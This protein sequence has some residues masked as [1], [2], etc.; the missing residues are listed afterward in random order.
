MRKSVLFAF[1]VS[2]AAVFSQPVRAENLT[3]ADV[4]QIVGRAVAEASAQGAGNGVIA[5]VDRV[6]NVLGVYVINPADPPMMTVT[7]GRGIPAGNGLEGLQIP[8]A[9]GAIAKAIT[10]AYLSSAGHAFSTRTASQIVQENFNPGELY[11]PGGPLFGVQFSQLPCSDI[12]QGGEALGP[13][14]RRSPLGLSADPGGLPLYRNGQVVGGVGVLFDGVYGLDLKISDYDRNL[15]ELIA[16]A[17]SQGYTP[18]TD[19]V[20]R[21]T[22]DGK[23]LRYADVDARF[24][25]SAGP[26]SLNP[27]NYVA[28]AGYTPA[29][30][31]EGT[32]FAS[33]ISG[34]R[35]DAGVS[36]PGLNA[37]VLDDGNGQNRYPPRASITPAVNA[38]GISATEAQSIVAEGL[39]VAFAARA[40]IRRP[41]GNFAQITVSVVDADG[42]VLALARTPDQPPFGIDVA[43]QKARSALFFSRPDAA[44]ELRALSPVSL[45]SGAIVIPSPGRYAD[46]MDTFVGQGALTGRVA[47]GAR[48]IG[49]LAR[50]FYPDG[51]NGQ[52]PGP[53]SL[54]FEHWSPF[55]DGLQLDLVLPDIVARIDGS[56]APASGCTALPQG[57]GPAATAPRRLADGLQ[58][59]PG[60]VPVYRGTTLIGG[61]GVSGDGIDQ[62]DMVAFLG[63]N[64]ASVALKTGVGNA[65][66]SIRADR[67]KVGGVNLRYVSCPVAPFLNSTAVNVC[68][69][70]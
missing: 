40:Q 67:L 8:A 43:V 29:G 47:Y 34:I 35:P 50:P 4:D 63:L 37:W 10:G 62:D 15:D 26:Q 53:L 31:R 69:G 59:F 51:I 3:V 56:V 61:V 20:S 68:D 39:K 55:N 58:I 16:L 12:N 32:L 23:I 21:I 38:G 22:V 57:A 11:T 1:L 42:N 27:N 46:A 7:S 54:A 65:P 24:L 52:P 66:V 28:V 25:K 17:A 60:G 2:L 9:F 64:N 5:V 33:V 6:G 45:L 30:R 70:K 41:L 19:I 36:Y 14:P 49:N 48:S 13:G 18:S 44:A